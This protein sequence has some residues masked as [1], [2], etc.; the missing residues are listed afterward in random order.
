MRR[1]TGD[2]PDFT[3]PGATGH[4][5][6]RWRRSAGV[7]LAGAMAALAGACRPGT[8]TPLRDDGKGVGDLRAMLADPDLEVQ[9]RG[10]FGLSRHGS[11]ARDAVPDL[12]PKLQS[13]SPL[14]RQNA[15][16]ALAAVGP[17]ARSAVPALAEALKDPEWTVRRQAALALGA[18]GP[19]AKPALPALKKLEADPHKVVAAAAR[20]ARQKIGG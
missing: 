1:G 19:D 13:Q 6:G 11:D 20:E 17:E 3:P 18:I 10:A 8:A 2:A 14:V 12:I 4:G 15:A 16:L 7:L 5:R 9:A